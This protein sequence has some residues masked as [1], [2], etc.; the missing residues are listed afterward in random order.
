MPVER[1][2][3]RGQIIANGDEARD[4]GRWDIAV[5][6]YSTLLVLE[7]D[8]APIRVQLGHGLKEL[9]R[10][11]E[12]EAAYRLAAS[13]RPNDP[14]VYVQIGHVLKL[15]GRTDDAVDA[16]AEA[17]RHEP[18]FEPARQELIAAGARNRLPE[19]LY[20]RSAITDAYVELSRALRHQG[21]ALDQLAAV[22]VFPIEAYD[23][24][25]QTYPLQPPPPH[26]TPLPHVCVLIDAQAQSPAEV[27]LSLDSLLEQSN[28]NWRAIVR[29]T[30]TMAAHSVATMAIKDPRITFA[31]R[32]ERDWIDRPDRESL[33]LLCDAGTALEPLGLDWL[34]TAQVQTGAA[35]AYADHDHHHHH[36]RNG[37]TYADPVRHGVPDPWDLETIP[38][39]PAAV[40]IG[41]AAHEGLDEALARSAGAL[42]RR[43]LI[44][45]ASRSGSRV[46]H[47]PLVLSSVRGALEERAALSRIIEPVASRQPQKASPLIEVIIPTRDEVAALQVCVESLKAKAFSS[48]SNGIRVVN[49]RS[50]DRVT[51]EYLQLLRDQG[52]ARIELFDEPFNWAR[53]NNR[54][55]ETSSADILVFANNDLEMLTS[56]WDRHVQ[57]RLSDLRIGVLG[58]RLLY[59]DRSVQHAGIV[60]GVNDLR[61]VHDGLGRQAREG[62]PQDRWLRSRQVAAVTGAFMAIRRDVFL[63]CGGFD[64]ALAIGYNDVDLCL[65]LR[66]GGLAVLYDPGIELI[67]HESKTRGHNDDPQK[68]AWD[69]AELT[70]LYARWG[71]WM[72][73]DPGKSP[74]WLSVGTRPFDG[75]RNLTKS[76]VLRH[77]ELSA[78]QNPWSIDR[79]IQFP[80]DVRL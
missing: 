8:N 34:A 65:R 72:I 76:Q 60:L 66:E 25:R 42:L 35:M 3:Q 63:E 71:E 4:Q 11:T 10:L 58:S 49:N 73:W 7:P 14:D 26:K 61:P 68:I 45:G 22:S 69:D 1:H 29:C 13:T 31:T 18:D 9:G 17:L 12:A 2:P 50:T 32:L 70:D 55:A 57:D 54:A 44:C 15:Q 80:E 59:P 33:V 23:A 77:I 74:S 36:W 37:R 6:H 28:S 40:L 51:S 52:Q 41:A 27:R 39:V 67:H 79:T 24:F 75:L 16:Y 20:G 46:V 38:V 62:G 19:A 56:D 48:S 43:S 47:I 5:E 21:R 78:R 64:E 53:L 30:E